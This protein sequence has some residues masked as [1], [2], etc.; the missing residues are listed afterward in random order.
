MEFLFS[1]VAILCSAAFSLISIASYQ[2][3]NFT[4][5]WPILCYSAPLATT[6]PTPASWF[7]ECLI[8]ASSFY[9]IHSHYFKRIASHNPSKHSGPES[10]VGSNTQLSVHT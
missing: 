10:A 8:S 5:G 4:P 6:K 9:L 3:V 7:T 2:K 1:C